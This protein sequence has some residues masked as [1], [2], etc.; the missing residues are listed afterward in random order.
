MVKIQWQ[1]V[2]IWKIFAH[3]PERHLDFSFS[4]SDIQKKVD[5]GQ[6]KIR[7][8]W[9]AKC[10]KQNWHTCSKIRACTFFLFFFLF[11]FFGF[12][13]LVFCFFFVLFCLLVCFYFFIVGCYVSDV[14]N[15][16]ALKQI[17]KLILPS[18]CHVPPNFK[19]PI[20]CFLQSTNTSVNALNECFIYH[21]F[22]LT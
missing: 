13:L 6:T 2:T 21:M 9:Q 3:L 10:T 18:I 5:L 14:I 12:F 8:I 16:Q 1:K 17:S 11:C 20:F 19:L 7:R 4:L 22:Y 15:K